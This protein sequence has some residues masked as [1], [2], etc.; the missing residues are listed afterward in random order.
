LPNKDLSLHSESSSETLKIEQK[1][2][3]SD[4]IS[5]EII[6]NNRSSKNNKKEN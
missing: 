1:S 6:Q 2:L 5:S 4:S 3:L